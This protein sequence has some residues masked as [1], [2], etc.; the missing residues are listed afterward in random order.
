MQNC[1]KKKGSKNAH[2]LK[3]RVKPGPWMR[4]KLHPFGVLNIYFHIHAYMERI[5]ITA[6]AFKCNGVV[7]KSRRQESVSV[8][9]ASLIYSTSEGDSNLAVI[10]SLWRKVFCKWITL[11]LNWTEPKG[12]PLVSPEWNKTINLKAAR[13]FYSDT[14]TWIPGWPQLF[15]FFTS[16]Q[17]KTISTTKWKE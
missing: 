4:G 5:L 3:H 2:V 16:L 6:R 10:S 17:D 13:V 1:W 14:G 12:E 8:P 11:N 7:P 9:S 15:S